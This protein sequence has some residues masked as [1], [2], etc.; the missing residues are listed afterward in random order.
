MRSLK[1][2]SASSDAMVLESSLNSLAENLL[3]QILD[4]S[5][6]KSISSYY[7]TR[8]R[9]PCSM[10]IATWYLLRLGFISKQVKNADGKMITIEPSKKLITILPDRFSTPENDAREIIE[11][12]PFKDA[13]NNIEIEFFESEFE[14]FSDWQKF[15]PEEYTKRN[16][17]S[18]VLPEDKEIIESV[19]QYILQ[20][21]DKIG[22][23]NTFTDVGCGPNLYPTILC[24]VLFDQN[25]S[26]QLM[27][28]VKANRKFIEE[29]L[30]DPVRWQPFLEIIRSADIHHTTSELSLIKSQSTVRDGSIY[31]RLPLKQDM[32]TSFFVAE[33]ITD[34]FEDVKRA[35]EQLKYNLRPDGLLV[36]AHMIGSHGY[37]AG[38]DSNFPA[39]PLTKEDVESLYED[40]E[41]KQ[42]VFV[43]HNDDYA[44]RKGYKGMAVVAGFV[45]KISS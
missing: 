2:A 24:S 18:G 32:I 25:T 1:D 10:Y 40:L 14:S 44:A 13:Y 43:S 27:D 23:I 15:D 28:P 37:F 9:Y 6:R 16:Y 29:S 12:T 4:K 3:E 5:I 19:A 20:R 17:F 41:D 31:D 11:S 38:W 8:H 33:S 30:E 7:K 26:I 34:T 21:Q 39:T 45:K 22:V 36:V 35:V 42:I